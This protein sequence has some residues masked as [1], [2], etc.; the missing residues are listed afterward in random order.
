MATRFSN[1][2][3]ARD[4]RWDA[5]KGLGNRNT[6]D[7]GSASWHAYETAYERRVF[8]QSLGPSDVVRLGPLAAAIR[9]YAAA[10]AAFD[11]LSA[12]PLVEAVVTN[13]RADLGCTTDEAI[14]HIRCDFDNAGPYETAKRNNVLVNKSG[15]EFAVQFM[16]ATLA[17]TEISYELTYAHPRFL[18]R[19]SCG[20]QAVVG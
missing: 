4:G 17:P 5:E 14:G 6:Y 18:P 13:V 19:V 12:F 7:E 16:T 15:E 8:N 9:G 11:A 20:G 1:P 3:A 10:T 2:N